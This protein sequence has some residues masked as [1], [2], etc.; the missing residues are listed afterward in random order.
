MENKGLK[1]TENK[2]E[3]DIDWSFAEQMAIRMSE[4]KDKYPRGNWK[5]PIAKHLLED[6]MMRHYIAYKKGDKSENHLAAIACNA[7]M[8]N[9]QE[10]HYPLTE[11]ELQ[12]IDEWLG[13]NEKVKS[14]IPYARYLIRY[15]TGLKVKGLLHTKEEYFLFITEK[16]NE[17]KY[18]IDNNIKS[19]TTNIID[20]KDEYINYTIELT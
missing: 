2:I 17:K 19:I 9:Y 4:N 6:A 12:V 1:E 13:E 18:W 7:M 3:Y 10:K 15:C 11:S 8:L 14:D 16:V 20:D 5:K